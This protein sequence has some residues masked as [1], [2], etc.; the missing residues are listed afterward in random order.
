MTSTGYRMT[1]LIT[2]GASAALPTSQ[3]GLESLRM[4]VTAMQSLTINQD[5][6]LTLAIE[7]YKDYLIIL[8]FRTER[9]HLEGKRNCMCKFDHTLFT[10]LFFSL[11]QSFACYSGWSAMARSR[12]TAT[13]A[14]RVQAILL[15]QPPE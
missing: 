9:H 7:G 11:R 12:L 6:L 10:F 4:V 1:A 8:C 5:G 15:P 3:M 2:N 14:S 13:S